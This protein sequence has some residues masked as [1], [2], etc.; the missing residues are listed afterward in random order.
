MMRK[1]FIIVGLVLSQPALGV[2][3][4]EEADETPARTVN[5]R[6][7]VRLEQVEKKL[8]EIEKKKQFY[9]ELREQRLAEI[10]KRRKAHE[11]AFAKIRS[12][13]AAGRT[14]AIKGRGAGG[15]YVKQKQMIKF[16]NTFS[17]TFDDGS[18]R[19]IMSV[20]EGHTLEL[21]SGSADNLED[22]YQIFRP[23][24]MDAFLPTAPGAIFADVHLEPDLKKISFYALHSNIGTPEPVPPVDQLDEQ[25]IKQGVIDA[26]TKA[27]TNPELKLPATVKS[28]DIRL[29][30]GHN[31]SGV[32]IGINSP[33]QIPQNRLPRAD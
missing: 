22:W 17:A 29:E 31:P 16:P 27:M 14:P 3:G 24:L 7:Q 9:K 6:L 10:E 25:L 8:Q 20:Q 21:V 4:Q 1:T 5:D 30:F 26:L 12:E 2:L 32:F 13:Q 19:K 33:D 23:R 28:V 11:E 18:T 15:L